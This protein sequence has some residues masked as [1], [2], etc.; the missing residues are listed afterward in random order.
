MLHLFN[1]RWKQNV[2]SWRNGVLF[3]RE[4][5]N[6]K[7]RFNEIT[8]HGNVNSLNW[9]PIINSE[10]ITQTQEFKGQKKQ[11]TLSL[12]TSPKSFQYY[13]NFGLLHQISK[14]TAIEILLQMKIS[15]KSI[16]L[17][18]LNSISKHSVAV[19]FPRIWTTK[20]EKILQFNHRW[21]FKFTTF[22]WKLY[23]IDFYRTSST[24]HRYLGNYQN[25]GI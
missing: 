17:K 3:N 21:S 8:L 19:K 5:Q 11:Y 20:R 15:R 7:H 25:S 9:K 1:C 22:P 16:Y 18:V 12:N 10:H 4:I 24:Q 6:V 2:C 23:N 14:N 13:Q